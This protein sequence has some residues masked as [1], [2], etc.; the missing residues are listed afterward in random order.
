MLYPN[1]SVPW[2]EADPNNWQVTGFGAA[3]HR[4][5]PDQLSIVV[6]RYMLHSTLRPKFSGW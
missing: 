3:Q 6:A 2:K 5:F 1:G 4:L